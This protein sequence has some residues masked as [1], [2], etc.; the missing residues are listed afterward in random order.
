MCL[1]IPAIY[2]C[3]M[4]P[5]NAVTYPGNTRKCYISA[6][7][8]AS[9][10]RPA[11]SL[12]N[13]NG[14]RLRLSEEQDPISP[15]RRR[16]A[17][18]SRTVTGA[19]LSSRKL[20]S[21]RRDHRRRSNITRNADRKWRGEARDRV[22]GGGWRSATRFVRRSKRKWNGVSPAVRSDQLGCESRPRSPAN[23]HYGESRS[24]VDWFVRPGT[25]L[26]FS[27][28]YRAKIDLAHRARFGLNSLT[29]GKAHSV[30]EDL[31]FL[32]RLFV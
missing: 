13:G 32:A 23:Q 7:T 3:A 12:R 14:F 31:L 17:V 15:D 25:T 27:R 8:L 4:R 16:S 9:S 22:G 21:R 2:S 24:T 30:F 26:R 6:A 10:I 18:S 20:H 11:I 1:P 29:H 5:R 28:R 19:H